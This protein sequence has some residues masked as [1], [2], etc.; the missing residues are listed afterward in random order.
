MIDDTADQFEVFPSPLAA[1]AGYGSAEMRVAGRVR[2]RASR[3]GERPERPQLGLARVDRLRWPRPHVSFAW[4][5]E[6]PR[7]LRA[8]RINCCCS[9]RA[10]S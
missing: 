1:D 7:G 5:G 10:V 8:Y 2:D 4:K 9:L 6:R 3:A